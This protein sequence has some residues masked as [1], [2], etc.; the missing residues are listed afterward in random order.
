MDL[1]AQKGINYTPITLAPVKPFVPVWKGQPEALINLTA[2]SNKAKKAKADG[3]NNE[4]IAAY[5]LVWRCIKRS[6]P[7]IVELLQD[8]VLQDLVKTF[9][10]QICITTEPTE[11]EKQ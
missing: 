9:G 10:G 8:P 5:N 2:I 7:K 3:N 6:R 4:D 1:L 11:E